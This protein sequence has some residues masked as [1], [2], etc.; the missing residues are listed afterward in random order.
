MQEN[1]TLS[2]TKFH[3]V[4]FTKSGNIMSSEYLRVHSKQ[5][6]REMLC[7]KLN[8]SPQT[9]KTQNQVEKN[10]KSKLREKI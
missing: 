7:I 4:I 10:F 9:H 2:I 5:N 3:V 8:K 6:T 1:Y